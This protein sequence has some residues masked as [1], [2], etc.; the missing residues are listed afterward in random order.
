MKEANSAE[1]NSTIV[2]HGQDRLGSILILPR[3]LGTH[4][5][6][7]QHLQQ[8]ILVTNRTQHAQRTLARLC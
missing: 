1:L 6:Q 2:E 7:D 4:S 3:L 8:L 5:R